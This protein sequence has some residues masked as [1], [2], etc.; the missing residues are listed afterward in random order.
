MSNV[1]RT[2]PVILERAGRVAVVRINRPE[3]RNAIDPE[4]SAI[5]EE[6][7]LSLELDDSVWAVILTGVGELAFCA[8]ADLKAIA[9]Q[10]AA[11]SPAPP[12]SPNGFAG[13]TNRLFQKP[14]VAAVNGLAVGGGFE[15][16]L[17]CDLVIAEDHATFALPEVRRGLVAAAGG[18]IRLSRLIPRSMALQ[19]ALTG[20]A[21]TA[22]DAKT[23]GLANE[24][25]GRGE[26]LNVAL[27]LADRVCQNAPLAV[28]ASKLLLR[29]AVEVGEADLWSRQESA[30]AAIRAS[31]DAREGPLAFAEKRTPNWQGR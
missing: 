15:L 19:M 3:V 10:R 23:L 8:G 6:T 5:L 31:Q 17:A 27:N 12:P 28:R 18:L 29:A 20:D 26:S 11:G 16:L 9:R 21:I 4:T 1:D 7:F 13:L 22:R 14:L 24:V 30:L 2:D 25:V